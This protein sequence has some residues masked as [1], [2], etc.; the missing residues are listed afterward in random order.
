M[1]EREREIP[2]MDKNRNLISVLL[3]VSP[4]WGN[5]VH[6]ASPPLQPFDVA[7][8]EDQIAAVQSSAPLPLLV[9]VCVCVQTGCSG[10]I[11]VQ[12][13]L[14]NHGFNVNVFGGGGFCQFNCLDPQPHY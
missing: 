9:C 10:S 13:C 4:R 8:N 5:Y 14:C 2:V 11:F 3:Q 12:L 7:D 6:R 1:K